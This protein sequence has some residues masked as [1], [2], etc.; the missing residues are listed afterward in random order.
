MS[1]DEPII[2][3][4]D[5]WAKFIAL[6]ERPVTSSPALYRLLIDPSV[7]ERVEHEI[8]IKYG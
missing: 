1:E 2:L 7:L 6:L 4:E 3:N 8:G 5:D